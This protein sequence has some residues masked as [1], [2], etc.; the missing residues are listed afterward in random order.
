MLT[1]LF[2]NQTLWCDHSLELSRRDNSNEGH[3]LGFGWEMRKFSWKPFSSFFLN[4][5]P[6]VL[7]YWNM[8]Y[9]NSTV[10][11]HAFLKLHH[12][13][14]F[15]IGHK[16]LGLFLEFEIRFHSQASDLLSVSGQSDTWDHC[17]H[18]LTCRALI[19]FRWIGASAL[20]S[21]NFVNKGEF[22]D[23]HFF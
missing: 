8:N 13:W 10:C 2:L 21:G 15:Y 20:G 1:F 4:W 6:G 11:E 23:L 12:K 14:Q 9:W 16:P 5:S 22:C 17:F 7:S 19:L 18:T 3:I